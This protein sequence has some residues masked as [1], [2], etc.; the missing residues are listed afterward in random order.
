VAG[1]A[2]A[3]GAFVGGVAVGKRGGLLTGARR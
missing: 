2:A 1:A 3:G